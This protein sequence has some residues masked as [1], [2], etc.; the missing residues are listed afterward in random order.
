MTADG[1]PP[2]ADD[3]SLG[4]QGRRYLMV[5]AVATAAHYL[6]MVLVVEFGHWRPALAAGAGAALGA[7]VAFAG[8]RWFTFAHRGPWLGAWGRFQVTALLGMATMMLGLALVMPL[9]GHASWHAY[10]DLVSFPTAD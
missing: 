6:L 9:L 7:Q 2:G 8:N 5:G 10:R 3:R 1:V 4:A